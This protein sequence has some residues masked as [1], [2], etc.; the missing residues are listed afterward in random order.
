MAALPSIS[1]HLRAQLVKMAHFLSRGEM[2]AED[3]AQ[4]VIAAVLARIARG[5]PLPRCGLEPFLF[6][7]VRNAV[8]SRYRRRKVQDRYLATLGPEEP[9]EAAPD[10]PAAPPAWRLVTDDQMTEALNTLS[11]KQR[12]VFLAVIG[13]E[14][15]ASI[16]ARQGISTGAVAKRVFDARQHLRK[17]LLHPRAST[18]LEQVKQWFAVPEPD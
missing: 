2:D 18:W 3:I 17:H 9:T 10:D 8:T 14:S 6:A 4:D 13:G 5:E 16:A 7:S 15:Y 12:D 1:A 11:Q